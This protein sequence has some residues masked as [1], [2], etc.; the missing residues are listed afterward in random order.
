MDLAEGDARG[1]VDRDVGVLPA[2]APG[3]A[4][5]HPAGAALAGPVAGDAVADLV[6]AAELLD[7]QM[8]QFA[9]VLTLIADDRLGRL[10]VPRPG[11][12]AGAENSAHSWA[13]DAGVG[14]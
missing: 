7:V 12:P 14:G 10:Q 13:G 8:D 11:Q 6:E 5:A 4:G 1:V 2:G 3:L 9:G